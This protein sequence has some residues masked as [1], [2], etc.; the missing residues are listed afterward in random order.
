MSHLRFSLVVAA[1]SWACAALTYSHAQTIAPVDSAGPA[2][3][4]SREPPLLPHTEMP[5]PKQTSDPAKLI[6]DTSAACELRI[7]GT[8]QQ[9]VLVPGEPRS[10]TVAPGESSIECTSITMRDAI[11]KLRAPV[12][13]GGRHEVSLDLAPIVA[14]ASCSG[15]PATLADLGHGVLRHCVTGTDWTQ[16]DSGPGGTEWAPARAYC[17]KKGPGWELP[18]PDELA[19]L[20]DRSGKSKTACGTHTC[21]I[22]PHFKLTSP[23]FWSN[24]ITGPTMIMIVNLILGGRHPTAED[25]NYDYHSLCVRRPA[26]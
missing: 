4:G 16:A 12:G 26:S 22:S 2:D 21:N 25:A 1:V 17:A 9:P 5:A 7:D 18:T 14:K 13:A 19:E 23:I 6:V 3:T 15:K 24:Q 20:I 8:A 11:V 10:V